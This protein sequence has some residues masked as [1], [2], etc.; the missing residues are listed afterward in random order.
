MFCRSEQAPRRIAAIPSAMIPSCP[1]VAF[2]V[3]A[4]AAGR[5]GVPRRRKL[6][7]RSNRGTDNPAD[8]PGA[9]RNSHLT[10]D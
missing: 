3:Y 6:K 1:F 8:D 10:H 7:I 5:Q 9:G 4:L 2:V